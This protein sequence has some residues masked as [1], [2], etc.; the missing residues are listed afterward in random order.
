[1]RELDLKDPAGSRRKAKK[2][3]LKDAGKK[4]NLWSTRPVSLETSR[5]L[6]SSVPD[7][8][9]QPRPV[10]TLRPK[11]DDGMWVFRTSPA[12]Q[13]DPYYCQT[14]AICSVSCKTQAKLWSRP[15]CA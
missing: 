5:V 10:L 14:L 7:R 6:R 3:W 11:D 13:C 9:L 8:I 15:G 12:A 4:W 1:M 2:L